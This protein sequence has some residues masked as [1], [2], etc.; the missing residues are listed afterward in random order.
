MNVLYYTLDA[1]DC[2]E[3]SGMSGVVPDEATIAP[4]G[5]TFA[6]IRTCHIDE[7]GELSPRPVLTALG[8]A[9]A[10]V[11]LPQCPADT[12]LTINELET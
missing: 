2:V 7:E 8:I 3:T 5:V 12:E 4:E 1:D 6:T 11:S 10:V 9:R